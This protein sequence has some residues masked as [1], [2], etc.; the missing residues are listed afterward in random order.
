[1]LWELIRENML[2]LLEFL[3]SVVVSDSGI[4]LWWELV[5][6]IST[7]L[8]GQAQYPTINPDFEGTS[9]WKKVLL[10]TLKGEKN[11]RLLS[12]FT[13]KIPQNFSDSIIWTR[14]FVRRKD[15]LIPGSCHMENDKNREVHVEVISLPGLENWQTLRFLFKG[16][17]NWETEDPILVSPYAIYCGFARKTRLD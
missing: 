1:M 11:L 13:C 2:E 16:I 14:K 9:T 10:R 15:S 5:P 17:L 4:F 12:A 6:S 3:D 8:T 7:V